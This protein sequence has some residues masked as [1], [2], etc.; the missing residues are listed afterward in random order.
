MRVPIGRRPIIE[1]GGV[2]SVCASAAYKV[3]QSHGESNTSATEITK[4][5]KSFLVN[6]TGSVQPAKSI[7]GLPLCARLS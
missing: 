2:V 5:L 3:N 1:R 6:C 7:C 4:R